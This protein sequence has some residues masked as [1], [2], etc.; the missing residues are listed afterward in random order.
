MGW[1]GLCHASL[2]AYQNQHHAEFILCFVFFS[3][4]TF[5]SVCI[6][7]FTFSPHSDL[8][9][10]VHLLQDA[11]YHFV[12]VVL[13]LSASVILA[14]ITELKGWGVTVTPGN[15]VVNV[16]NADRFKIYRLDIAAVV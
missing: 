14:Y 9:L 5:L 7:P 6:Y 16:L 11:G 10:F 12:A 13:Y 4:P 3:S 8:P 2:L 15:L 1:C